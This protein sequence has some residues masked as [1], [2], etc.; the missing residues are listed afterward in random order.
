MGSCQQ[1]G[2]PL[3]LMSKSWPH[4]LRIEESSRVAQSLGATTRSLRASSLH[5]TITNALRGKASPHFLERREKMHRKGRKC[6]HS[7]FLFL[8]G[9]GLG[10]QLSWS[11]NPKLLQLSLMPLVL[12]SGLTT[13]TTGTHPHDGNTKVTGGKSDGWAAR[14]HQRRLHVL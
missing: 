12:R 9:S 5:L 14:W 1:P 7:T 2:W 10:L 4:L 8:S 3:L 13:L 11:R 6:L